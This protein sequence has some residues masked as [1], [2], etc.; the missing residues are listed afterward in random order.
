MDIDIILEEICNKYLS[1]HD[2]KLTYND[3]NAADINA[4]NCNDYLYLIVQ[5]IQKSVFFDK[6]IVVTI[7]NSVPIFLD[8]KFFEI[9]SKLLK[10]INKNDD[11][12][13]GF[14]HEFL[15]L[16]FLSLKNTVYKNNERCSITKTTFD[17]YIYRRDIFINFREIILNYYR[18][19]LLSE[20]YTVDFYNYEF[21]HRFFIIFKNLNFDERD[22][23]LIIVIL[24][25]NKF[26][27]LIY[28][29]L[30]VTI[31]GNRKITN[32][33][34]QF[35]KDSINI[36][37]DEKSA[38]IMKLYQRGSL[39]DEILK[40]SINSMIIKINNIRKK[41]KDE[42][43]IIIVSEIEEL[44]K[45]LNSL[46]QFIKEEAYLSKIKECLLDLL[47]IKR[48]LLEDEENINKNMHRIEHKMN[49]DSSYIESIRHEIRNNPFNI[50]S[51]LKIDFSKSL[52]NA[53][54]TKSN[55]ALS[56]LVSTIH[57]NS[58]NKVYEIN[59]EY[60]K[61]FKDYYEIIGKGL[62]NE[63]SD[64]K[65]LLNYFNEN[66][67][68]TLIKYIN[69]TRGASENFILSIINFD[70]YFKDLKSTIDKII[71]SDFE[72]DVLYENYYAF[73]SKIIIH[74]E[75][76]LTNLYNQIKD[77]IK[78]RINEPSFLSE[79]F[80]NCKDLKIK[81]L[82]FYLYF[83]LYLK[84]G[85]NLR[86]NIFHGNLVFNDNKHNVLRITSCLVSLSFI[87]EYYY[88]K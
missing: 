10:F 24:N 80:F 11:V 29:L 68:D 19:L 44:N 14:L 78:I 42:N 16:Y 13:F 69:L 2:L 27:P 84:E 72:N 26:I 74:I 56:F 82:I 73:I 45:S 28:N 81:N 39:D 49:I 17:K 8:E 85:Y 35:L 75:Q 64:K 63:L 46:N 62:E 55:N 86:D 25:K 31:K 9:T 3:L 21:I 71:E 57:I 79:L 48:E 52:E 1:E 60:E 83:N 20:K 76:S 66:Y 36:T 41:A 43:I 32:I 58:E 33:F 7:F 77:T 12:I 70:E 67:Y 88:G 37:S 30:P 15:V 6:G 50:F 65:E 40:S 23:D 4:N 54:K 34:N 22:I 61:I 51:L 53:I 59:N 47:F 18:I 38:L 87:E 5:S